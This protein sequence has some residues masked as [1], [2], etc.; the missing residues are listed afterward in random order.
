MSKNY[1]YKRSGVKL[2]PDQSQR[3]ITKFF[4]SKTSSTIEP[5]ILAPG[6]GNCKGNSTELT[7]Y[8]RSTKSI[9]DIDSNDGECYDDEMVDEESKTSII[10]KRDETKTT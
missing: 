10:L 3:T 7:N 4:K 9:S 5:G 1:N 8:S 6:I 2:N